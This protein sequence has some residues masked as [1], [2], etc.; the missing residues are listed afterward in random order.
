LADIKNNVAEVQ[1]QIARFSDL[2]IVGKSGRGKTFNLTITIHGKPMKEVTI[3][4]NII[5]VTVDGPRDSRN[6]N[7]KMIGKY[8]FT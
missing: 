5:K 4:P 3:V 8:L 7:N 6:P 2:R 1:S